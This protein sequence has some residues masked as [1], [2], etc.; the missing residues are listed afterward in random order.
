MTQYKRFNKIKL[1]K[2]K[3][4]KLEKKVKPIRKFKK[5]SLSSYTKKYCVYSINFYTILYKNLYNFAIIQYARYF[6]IKESI[7]LSYYALLVLK[8]L[9]W[10]FEYKKCLALQ[11][12][13]INYTSFEYLYN[14]EKFLWLNIKLFLNNNLTKIFPNSNYNIYIYTILNKYLLSN[15]LLRD[16]TNSLLKQY[17]LF[18]II[19]PLIYELES[20]YYIKGFKICCAGRFARK[21]RATYYWVKIKKLPLNHF[22]ESIDYGNTSVSLRYGKC[23][24]KVWLYRKKLVNNWLC[25][26]I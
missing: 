15:I 1:K 6:S 20:M 19:N 21:Q 17:T 5:S 18:E 4:K 12:N 14:S 22:A 7:Y 2:L 10:I 11:Y 25:S 24:I 8:R 26:I 16:I 9:T 23:G 3:F 13:F